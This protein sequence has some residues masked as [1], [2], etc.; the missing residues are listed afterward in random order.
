[1]TSFLKSTS[2]QFGKACLISFGIGGFFIEIQSPFYV[3]PIPKRVL[4]KELKYEDIWT[5]WQKGGQL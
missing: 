3:Q 4:I 1:M 5:R 2:G